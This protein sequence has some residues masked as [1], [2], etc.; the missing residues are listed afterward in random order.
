MI[1][2]RICRSTCG[3]RRRRRKASGD[4]SNFS[5]NPFLKFVFSPFARAHRSAAV[6]AQQSTCS[7]RRRVR[8]EEGRRVVT[9]GRVA[10]K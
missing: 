10:G 9:R 4:N 6:Q 1:G 3:T 8:R 7:R 2:C 5:S